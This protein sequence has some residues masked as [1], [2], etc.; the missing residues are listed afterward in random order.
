MAFEFQP[1][2]VIHSPFKEKF[3]IP[4]QPGLVPQA[5]ATLELL[6]PYNLPE[7]VEGL[8]GYSHIWIQ[9]LFQFV[10]IVLGVY[11]ARRAWAA[12]GASACSPAGRRLGR[13]PSGCR[14]WYWRMCA[15]LAGK[16]RWSW[17]A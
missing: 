3:G 17:A 12:T 13:I 2:G 7:A 5:R 4:R 6:P 10:I 15:P 14:W 1:I 9:F 16:W 11:L 8:S